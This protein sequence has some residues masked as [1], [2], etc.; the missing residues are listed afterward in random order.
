MRK[1]VGIFCGQIGTR[2]VL[3]ELVTVLGVTMQIILEAVGN[4]GALGDDGDFVLP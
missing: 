4:E 2:A 1:A 3:R